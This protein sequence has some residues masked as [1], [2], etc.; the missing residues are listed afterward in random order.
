MSFDTVLPQVYCDKA[1]LYLYQS[2]NDQS[3]HAHTLLT[4]EIQKP[5][6]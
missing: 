6:L 2:D 1:V 4:S 3:I 5:V